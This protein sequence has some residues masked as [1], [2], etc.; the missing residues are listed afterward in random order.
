VGSLPLL[1]A[2][3]A[4]AGVAVSPS[5]ITGFGLAEQTSPRSRL[6]ESLAWTSTALGIGV[7]V[8]AA[9]AGPIIDTRGASAAFG[10]AVA[11]G[12]VAV[13]SAAV[14]PGPARARGVPAA[15]TAA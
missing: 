5:L 10:V 9:L 8:G 7:A 13:L 14:V 6:N 4:V 1:A 3:L 15:R 11:A 12:V 2:V